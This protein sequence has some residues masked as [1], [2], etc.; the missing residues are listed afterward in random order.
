M[1]VRYSYFEDLLPDLSEK[2]PLG[3]GS[4]EDVFG[5][6]W[7]EMRP[8]ECSRVKPTLVYP[9]LRIDARSTLQK[10]ETFPNLA[11]IIDQMFNG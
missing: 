7:N 10:L 6:L 11:H 2:S 1:S 9:L 5:Y 8:A 4:Q 3:L